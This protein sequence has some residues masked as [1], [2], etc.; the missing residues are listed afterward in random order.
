L[1]GIEGYWARLAGLLPPLIR[2]LDLGYGDLLG[3]ADPK[4][5]GHCTDIGQPSRFERG[6]KSGIV[7]VA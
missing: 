2:W 6:Q 3:Q 4:G 7:A 5:A 1:G